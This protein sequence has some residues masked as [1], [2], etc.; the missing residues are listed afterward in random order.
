MALREVH[1]TTERRSRDR[2]QGILLRRRHS[3][4]GHMRIER[5][6]PH[7]GF[8]VAGALELHLE[9]Y[10][11]LEAMLV[12]LEAWRYA[13]N[14]EHAPEYLDAID[15]AVAVMR[16]ADEPLHAIAMLQRR[17]RSKSAHDS[18]RITPQLT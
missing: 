17:G 10:P 16:R 2:S 3:Q 14:G 8:D 11:T 5:R 13:A 12:L 4:L 1:P 6:R 15:H 7:V 18:A 9:D